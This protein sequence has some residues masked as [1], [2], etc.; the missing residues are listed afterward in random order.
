[1][2]GEKVTA[3]R[4]IT[5]SKEAHHE[6]IGERSRRRC[7]AALLVGREHNSNGYAQPGQPD[8]ENTR[9]GQLERRSG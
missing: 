1:M 7:F 5:N 9:L 8:T 4:A 3:S 2:D 6:E